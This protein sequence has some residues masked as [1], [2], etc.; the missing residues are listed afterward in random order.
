MIRTPAEPEKARPELD[1]HDM[2]IL[3]AL[4]EDGRMSWRDLSE[5][6][7]LSLTPTMR[8]VRKMEESGLIK[9]YTALLDETLV[10]G[11]SIFVMLTLDRQSEES[12][13]RFEREIRTVPEVMSCFMMTGDNDYLARIIVHNLEHYQRVLRRLTAIPNIAHIKSSVALRSVIQR[14]GVNL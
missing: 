12:L 3:D 2:S 6:I 5:R 7:G 9:G 10:G 13:D 8:R 11:L 14:R 1:S 4:V